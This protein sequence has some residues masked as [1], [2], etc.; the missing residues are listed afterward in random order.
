M[1]KSL[2]FLFLFLGTVLGRTQT[3]TFYNEGQAIKNGDSV[4]SSR[5]YEE[6]KEIFNELKLTPEITLMSSVDADAGKVCISLKS[7]DRYSVEICAGGACISAG[8][9]NNW[10]ILKKN[11]EKLFA[12][13]PVDMGID[14]WGEEGNAIPFGKIVTVRSE[15]S[16]WYEGNEDSKISFTLVM[17]SDPTFAG[18]EEATT[19]LPVVCVGD[20]VLVYSLPCESASLS[21]YSIAGVE[22][23]THSLSGSKGTVSL[24]NLP[25]GL[26]IYKLQGGVSACGKII[27]E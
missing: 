24:A 20:G 16:A 6:S 2:L 5:Y 23:L 14:Y 26:Y 21:L 9:E 27:V 19:A 18:V 17:T 4:V 7:L 13:K 10:T 1:K 11:T 22:V 8:S 25:V 3:L 12:G 15:V